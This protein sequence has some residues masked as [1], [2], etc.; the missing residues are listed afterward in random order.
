M[1]RK[2]R[3]SPEWQWERALI[4]AYADHR[5]HQ[6]LDPLHDQL[7][8]WERGELT[9]DELDQ[10]IHQ[11]HKETQRLYTLFTERRV[12]LVHMTQWNQE[13]FDVWV[14]QHPPPPTVTLV[15][16]P[17][18]MENVGGETAEPGGQHT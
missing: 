8:R 9:H 17:E 5:W 2:Q 11:T 10:A 16:R 12:L 18:E 13:W 6:L 7:H 3:H 15:S 14:A 1:S 4:D